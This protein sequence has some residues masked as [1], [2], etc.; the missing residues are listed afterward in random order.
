MIPGTEPVD[1]AAAYSGE[2][3]FRVEGALVVPGPRASGPWSEE[4]LNGRNVVA[5]CAWAVERDYGADG[6]LC[7]RLVV[8]LLRPVPRAPLR[9]ETKAVRSGGRL[10][11]VDVELTAD[12]TLVTRA[13][14]LL[15]RPS[16]AMPGGP[17]RPPEWEMPHPDTLARLD[18]EQTRNVRLDVRP[19]VEGVFFPEG[20]R[21]LWVREKI[22]L[23]EGEPWTPFMRAA[24]VA[25][26]ANPLA[27][28][29]EVLHYINAD[30]TVHLARL[31]V[32]EWIGIETMDHLAADGICLGGGS[33][34]DLDGRIGWSSVA[35]LVTAAPPVI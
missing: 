15:L 17:W 25:D 29:A 24:A 22:E 27:N 21:R 33:I 31:P 20:R 26:L 9:V 16:E 34:Y 2:P 30:V 13:T 23:V 12:G 10:R 7:A 8:D 1:A 18:T 6:L 32:G 3:F 11:A 19:E 28:R 14:A 4:M 35:C 5:L